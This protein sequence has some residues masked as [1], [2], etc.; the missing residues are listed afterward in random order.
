MYTRDIGHF[1]PD[2]LYICVD[3]TSWTDP[4]SRS[5]STL[6][7]VFVLQQ[8]VPFAVPTRM[9]N[10]RPPPRRCVDPCRNTPA[11]VSRY[12]SSTIAA[13]TVPSHHSPG[14]TSVWVECPTEHCQHELPR[15][16]AKYPKWCPT[17]EL[18]VGSTGGHQ[19]TMHHADITNNNK[20][21]L[22]S[23]LSIRRKMRI[24]W[25]NLMS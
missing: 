10:G 3:I 20:L 19:A 9:T 15:I 7:Y 23:Q 6:T 5:R 1:A 14:S 11:H 8:E 17:L 13:W 16:V 21:I 12:L 4:F 18:P 25:R 24:S 2:A 22:H